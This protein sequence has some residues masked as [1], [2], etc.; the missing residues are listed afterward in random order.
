MPQTI[1]GQPYTPGQQPGD[2]TTPATPGAPDAE[3][4]DDTSFGGDQLSDKV[5][6]PD[7]DQPPAEGAPDKGGNPFA[8]KD[9]DKSKSKGGNPFAKGSAFITAEG[10]ALTEDEYMAHIAFK[11]T[12]RKDQTLAEVQRL[13]GRS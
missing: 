3:G 11:F 4:E 13:H 1:D 2:T 10:V 8:K 5:E 7:D 6:Q 12:H 9:D